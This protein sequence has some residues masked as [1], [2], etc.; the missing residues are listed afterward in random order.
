MRNREK[1]LLMSNC[2]NTSSKYST[3]SLSKGRIM[4]F[5]EIDLKVGYQ[6]EN[7]Q[8]SICCVFISILSSAIK[9]L[10]CF[11]LTFLMLHFKF[12]LFAFRKLFL[13][14]KSNFKIEKKRNLIGFCKVKSS[15]NV[16]LENWHCDLQTF[17]LFCTHRR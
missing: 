14:F 16:L 7:I 3:N 13:N 12:H 10:F 17:L 6:L 1:N 15:L 2:S 8:F 9:S 11:F 5:N 4:L